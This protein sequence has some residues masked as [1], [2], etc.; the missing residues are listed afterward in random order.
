MKQVLIN[1]RATNVPVVIA[2]T[3]ARRTLGLM[4]EKQGSHALLLPRCRSI[5]TFF[6]RYPIDVI[7]MDKNYVVVRVIP[8]CKPWRMAVPGRGTCH[9]LE[10]PAGRFPGLNITAGD[11]V[12]T[13]D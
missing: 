12:S 3:F 11:V 8:A 13:S 6:M 9:I 2:D 7:C 1:G 4:G 5:H 10:I